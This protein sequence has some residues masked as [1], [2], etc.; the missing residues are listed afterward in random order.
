[1][2]KVF[3]DET[4]KRIYGFRRWFKGKRA[5]CDIT[6]K[7]LARKIGVDQSNVSHMLNPKGVEKR[8]LTYRDLLILFDAV[9][10]TDE[11]ILRF[12]RLR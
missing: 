2:P 7:D 12:M 1:M 6:Q 9:N 5:E 3:A 10:A 4:E 11:E 8:Q